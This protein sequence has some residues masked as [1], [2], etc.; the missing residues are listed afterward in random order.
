MVSVLVGIALPPV[1]KLSKRHTL[2]AWHH[3]RSLGTVLSPVMRRCCM[4]QS[5]KTLL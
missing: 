2:I 5:A 3:H 1:P 4:K